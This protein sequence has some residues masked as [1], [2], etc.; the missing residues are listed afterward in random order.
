VNQ[1]HAR[2][3][4][5]IPTLDVA[6]LARTCGLADSWPLP[7]Q[8]QT[9]RRF[10]LLRSTAEN[11]LVLGRL[12]EAHADAVAIIS[13]L[14][15]PPIARG[16]RWGVWAAGP[17]DSLQA[18]RPGPAGWRL[19][20]SQAWCSGANLVTHALVD[21]ATPDGQQ[22]FAV[23]LADPGIAVGAPTWVGAGMI[24]AD[25]RSVRFHHA[26][27]VAVGQPGEY[28]TRPGFWAGAIGVAACWQ[29][30]TIAVARPLF[31]RSRRRPE[32]HLL[33]HLGAVHVNVEQNQAILAAAARQLDEHFGHD[34]Q[35]LA[36]TVRTAI[37][38]NAVAVMDRV[39]RAL[40][41]GPLAHD[42]HHAALVADLTV[43]IRQHHGERDL[44]QIGRRLSQLD[45]PWWNCE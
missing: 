3:S 27:G 35:V 25:T 4:L 22:L 18:C 12:V 42:A 17:A 41:P 6:D 43:Y 28:L 10:D 11:D 45:D 2:H 9:A 16:R 34:H 24:R 19:E 8:G 31:E 38:R 23:D 40:G 39:G 37:E 15:G 26:T 36:G 13:E 44:E 1:D 7:G 20:G 5:E 29:G 33:A 32:P 30:G 14:N 21:A